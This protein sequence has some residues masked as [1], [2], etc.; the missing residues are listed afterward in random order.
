MANIGI[1]TGTLVKR[2]ST[3]KLT[4]QGVSWLG[5]GVAEGIHEL[6]WSW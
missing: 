5:G 4:M 6:A 3:S 1:L 2:D